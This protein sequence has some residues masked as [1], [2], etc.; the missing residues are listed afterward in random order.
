LL[1][2]DALA[3]P[4]HPAAGHAYFISDGAPVELWD[5]INTLLRRLGHPP[6]TRRISLVAARSIGSMMEIFWRTLPF[7]PGE[8]PMTRFVAAELAKD[9]WYS[10]SAARRDLGYQPAPNLSREMDE[11]VSSLMP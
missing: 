9:H 8:P 11:L 5:W 6:V 1:A 2:L 10:I 7:L 4:G 3:T